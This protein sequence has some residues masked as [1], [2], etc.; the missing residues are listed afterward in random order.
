MIFRVGDVSIG[1]SKATTQ[2]DIYCFI[3]ILECLQLIETLFSAAKAHLQTHSPTDSFRLCHFQKKSY[4]KK[5]TVTHFTSISRYLKY[6]AFKLQG[7][8]E[9]Q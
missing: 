5:N 2:G 8:I 3:S 4:I 1:T 6:F 9:S 7:M